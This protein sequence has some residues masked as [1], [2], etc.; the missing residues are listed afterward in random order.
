MQGREDEGGVCIEKSS[1]SL[2]LQWLEILA[3]S[4]DFPLPLS[5]SL[6]LFIYFLFSF[7]L[8]IILFLS[9]SNY[10]YLRVRSNDSWASQYFHPIHMR[11]FCHWASR[12]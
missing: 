9:L 2:A 1:S 6:H 11:M 8:S 4:F 3:D 5:L 7:S 10:R 12:P